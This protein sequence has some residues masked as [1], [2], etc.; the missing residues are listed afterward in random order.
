[1]KF[2]TSAAAPRSGG[3]RRGAFELL[4]AAT[5][6]AL[7][8][9]PAASG[10]AGL[11][12]VACGDRLTADTTLVSNLN[13]PHGLGLDLAPGITLDLAGH[14]ISGEGTGTIGINAEDSATIRGGRITGFNIGVSALAGTIEDM[15]IRHNGIGFSGSFGGSRLTSIVSSSISDNTG[16]GISGSNSFVITDSEILRNGGGAIATSQGLVLERSTVANNGTLTG[17]PLFALELLDNRVVIKDSTLVNSGVLVFTT[18]D[19]I[20]VTG[21]TFLNSPVSIETEGTIDQDG[22][23]VFLVANRFRNN[24]SSSGTN[25][26]RINTDGGFPSPSV[27][28]VIFVAHNEFLNVNL[29]FTGTVFDGGGNTGDSCGTL[30]SCGG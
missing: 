25:F 4:L 19:V 13:C 27:K 11:D 17:F 1:M 3:F 2:R 7:A 22:I 28:D 16:V 18:I 9:A 10:R 14:T 21:S 29:D 26:L 24:H 20:R 15:V 8:L 12:S 5:L 23:A 6:A 30:I